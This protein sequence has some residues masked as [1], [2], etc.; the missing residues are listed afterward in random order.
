VHLERG[1][2]SHASTTPATNC[3]LPTPHIPQ[4]LSLCV[5]RK[6]TNGCHLAGVVCWASH[7]L[8]Q[9]SFLN[10]SF[11][12]YKYSKFKLL[13]M[14]HPCMLFVLLKLIFSLSMNCLRNSVKEF[15]GHSS[16]HLP[17]IYSAFQ[18]HIWIPKSP[19]F[20]REFCCGKI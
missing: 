13:V 14:T 4:S 11:P 8:M 10:P 7:F 18:G 16:F 1:R 2:E 6:L 12:R 20:G 19:I 15:V 5:M 17:A 3:L 9:S